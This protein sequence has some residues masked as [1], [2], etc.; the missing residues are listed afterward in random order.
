M[1]RLTVALTI[2]ISISVL[3]STA[4][5]RYTE[6]YWKSMDLQKQKLLNPEGQAGKA[7]YEL[8]RAVA[9]AFGMMM[10]TV[11][12]SDRR[13]KM[14]G[15]FKPIR[16]YDELWRVGFVEAVAPNA[17]VTKLEDY[18][19]EKTLVMARLDRDFNKYFEMTERTRPADV[20]RD[21]NLQGVGMP[22][23]G[24][25]SKWGRLHNLDFII[26]GVTSVSP[27][28]V[29]VSL[30]LEHLLTGRVVAVGSS[31]VARSAV[32]DQFLAE[33]ANVPQAPQN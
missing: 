27:G 30:K 24:A 18:V 28:M 10:Q 29:D 33:P 1:R 23:A 3:L 11:P 26:T 14:P 15:I 7:E 16:F 25:M 5:S 31:K 12:P 9:E 8:D 32:I 21:L 22:D 20:F 4:C 19:A 2:A 17:Q 13:V 6:E